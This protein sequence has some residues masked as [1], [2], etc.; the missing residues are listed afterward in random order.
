MRWRH[1]G[2]L[3]RAVRLA[4]CQN[5]H[6]GE[7]PDEILGGLERITLPLRERIAPGRTF[8][9][10]MYVPAQAAAALVVGDDNPQRDR[11]AGFLQEHGLDPFT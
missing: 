5:L 11:L 4:Y 8:G 6:P 10:G 3:D 9:V 2:H 1:P 7:T